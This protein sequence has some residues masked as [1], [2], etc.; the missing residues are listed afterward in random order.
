MMG[1]ALQHEKIQ[2]AYSNNNIDIYRYM[3]RE[4][5]REQ[6]PNAAK[7]ETA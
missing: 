3:K 4:R 7:N 5:E 6:A 2:N 1:H